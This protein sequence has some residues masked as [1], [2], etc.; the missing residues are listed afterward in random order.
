MGIE[1]PMKNDQVMQ[2][3]H[4]QQINKPLGPGE[5]QNEN[6]EVIGRRITPTGQH[7]DD[8]HSLR[9]FDQSGQFSATK[10]LVDDLSK[11][12]QQQQQQSETQIPSQSQQIQQQLQQQQEQGLV[13]QAAQAFGE[14]KHICE[15]A[16][17]NFGEMALHKGQELKDQAAHAFEAAKQKGHEILDTAQ[18]KAH[19]VK[20]SA[21][22]AF[23]GA[24]HK[25]EEAVCQV[26][27]TAHSLGERAQHGATILTDQASQALSLAMQKG[28]DLKE[29]AEKKLQE[30]TNEDLPN[31]RQ[32][33]NID[34]DRAHL[35]WLMLRQHILNGKKRAHK[36]A[37][38]ETLGFVE[39]ENPFGR[40]IVR[41]I[42]PKL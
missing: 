20:E 34:H 28:H 18:H 40:Q 7:V 17:H 35:H 16:A 22:Q 14:A 25:C 24:K 36:I 32:A 11:Q 8:M 23:E 39:Y 3:T 27:T 2:P 9:S 10:R 15:E 38:S 6:L 19:D 5:Q 30:L 31:T 26:K 1:G 42:H 21:S 12:E 37:R 29:F 13:E 41:K 33:G 4:A